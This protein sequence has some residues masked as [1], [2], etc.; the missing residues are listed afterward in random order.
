VPAFVGAPTLVKASSRD[1]VFPRLFARA[2][3][4]GLERPGVG[5][6]LRGVVA[7]AQGHRGQ[8]GGAADTRGGGA[9][10]PDASSGSAPPLGALQRRVRERGHLRPGGTGKRGAFCPQQRFRGT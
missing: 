8:R 3:A 5:M 7:A 9:G 1:D 2:L 6:G 10:A 4:A